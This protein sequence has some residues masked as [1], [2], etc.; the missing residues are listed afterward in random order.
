M[1]AKK[2][3][4]SSVAQSKKMSTQRM[5]SKSNS[6]MT[7]SME[8]NKSIPP[9]KKG[10]WEAQQKDTFNNPKKLKKKTN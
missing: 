2:A 1:A 5:S 8:G 9:S 7:P 6:K 4:D 10:K 3:K